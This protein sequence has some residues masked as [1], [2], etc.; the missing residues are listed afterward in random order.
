MKET[1][2]QILSLVKNSNYLKLKN[3]NLFE[4]EKI[5]SE[6]NSNGFTIENYYTEKMQ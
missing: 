5:L 2:K 1:L 6:L 4:S 3:K